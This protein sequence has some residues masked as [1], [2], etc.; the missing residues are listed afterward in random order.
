MRIA[1]GVEYDGTDF[2]GWQIQSGVRTV[3]QCLEEALGQVAD[4]RVQ[5]TCAGRTDTGV[6]AVGQVVH[7]DT[8]ADREERAWIL[9]GN[10]NLPRDVSIRWAR[11]VPERFHARFGARRRRYRYLILNRRTRPAIGRNRVCWV[12]QPL[13]IERMRRAARYL[14][15]EHDFSSYRAVACQAKSPIR[16]VYQLDVARADEVIRIDVEANAFLHHM[17]RNIAGVLI[18]IGKGEREPRWSEEVLHYRDRTLGGVT[19]PAHGLYFMSV[20][21]DPEFDLPAVSSPDLPL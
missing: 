9:G 20:S 4:H 5:V 13:E 6:H 17:V 14:V 11:P 15:G 18:T 7:F 3:Q 21:Y 1:L 16:T 10:A 12:H 8:D 19:A 2:C